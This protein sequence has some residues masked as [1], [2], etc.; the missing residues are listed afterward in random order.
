MKDGHIH[1]PFCPHGSK[2][3]LK[4]YIE[5]AI[6]LGYQ[7]MTFTEHAPLPES[8]SDPVPDK[9]SGMSSHDVPDYL[10]EIKQLKYEYRKD[11]EINAGFEVDYIEGYEKETEKFLNEYGPE[12]DDSILSVHFLKGAEQW[13]CID[14]STSMFQA[15]LNDFGS[16]YSLYERYFQTLYK[17]MEAELGKYKPTRIGHMTLIRKFQLLYPSPD[18]WETM[19]GDL[20]KYVKEMN[21][22][23]DYNGA[24]TQKPHC[25]ETYPPIHLA[26]EASSMGIPLVYGSDAHTAS[27]LKQ[28]YEHI[29]VDLLHSSR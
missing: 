9:D 26:R 4:D 20:M 7:S 22:S 17:S 8:F 11:I 24:G 29:D 18:R 5:K 16:I 2:D 10:K 3:S 6:Q 25:L 14:F 21:Y 19:A 15:A 1:T 28:G 13:Y 12:L 23:L 27:G